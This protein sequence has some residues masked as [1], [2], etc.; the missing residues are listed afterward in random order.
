MRIN[1]ADMYANALLLDIAL[2]HFSGKPRS[3]IKL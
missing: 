2:T 3:Q 1:R